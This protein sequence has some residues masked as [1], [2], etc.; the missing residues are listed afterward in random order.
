MTRMFVL[1]LAHLPTIGTGPGSSPPNSSTS[2]DDKSSYV[3]PSLSPCLG[4]PTPRDAPSVPISEESSGSSLSKTSEGSLSPLLMGGMRPL[5]LQPHQLH[6]KRQF[7]VRR[8]PWSSAV[9]P[10]CR[11]SS[12]PFSANRT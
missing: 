1:P 9:K 5:H 12:S 11:P 2:L 4:P 7:V 10:S 3:S 6:L 8:Y